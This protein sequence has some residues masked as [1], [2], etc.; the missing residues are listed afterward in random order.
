MQ[1]KNIVLYIIVN[2]VT[3]KLMNYKIIFTIYYITNDNSKQ[4]KSNPRYNTA[5]KEC[6]EC[7]CI[8][9]DCIECDC[10]K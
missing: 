6:I 4:H 1:L 9:C 3:L 5:R 7:E 10:I 2:K 8:E